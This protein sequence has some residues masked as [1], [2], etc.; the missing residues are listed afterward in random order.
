[1]SA[2]GGVLGSTQGSSG[3]AADAI[4]WQSAGKDQS[5][6]EWVRLKR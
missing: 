4:S 5:S 1:M 6:S 2:V 3:E